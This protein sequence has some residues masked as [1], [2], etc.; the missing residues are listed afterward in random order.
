MNK[1]LI[2]VISLLFSPHYCFSQND[3][4]IIVDIPLKNGKVRLIKDSVSGKIVELP[5]FLIIESSEKNVLS[6]TKGVVNNIIKNDKG[7]FVS[8]KM[9]SGNFV[10]YGFLGIIDC[11]VGMQIKKNKMIGMLPQNIN[12]LYFEFIQENYY[13]EYYK[14]LNFLKQNGR[15]GQ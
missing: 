11:K 14:T 3:S 7:Y 10:V 5:P 12:S 9:K 6:L 4:T 2:L 13:S 1:L 8:I 15:T